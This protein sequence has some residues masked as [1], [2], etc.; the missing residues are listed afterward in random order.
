MVSSA[1]S[2]R[3][4]RIH[5]SSWNSYFSEKKKKIGNFPLLPQTL[6]KTLISD[7]PNQN[8]IT[9]R[10]PKSES[11]KNTQLVSGLRLIFKELKVLRAIEFW[12]GKK[13]HRFRF[14][15]AVWLGRF[16]TKESSKGADETFGNQPNVHGFH[17]K[18][19]EVSLSVSLRLS[20]C[21]CKCVE[22]P[23]WV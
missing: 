23:K 11:M 18:F 12:V 15:L 17:Q 19:L 6:L 2:H 13:H 20:G 8:T 14:L 5:L 21:V 7:N 1:G 3:T 22:E 10:K 9:L 16:S 4:A